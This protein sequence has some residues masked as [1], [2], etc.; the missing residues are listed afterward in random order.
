MFN[1]LLFAL[2][3]SVLAKGELHAMMKLLNGKSIVD[4]FA[5]SI[6][7]LSGSAVTHFKGAEPTG[8]L[9]WKT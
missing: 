1:V 7:Y 2:V 6:S 5:D 3:P 9:P 4:L 8:D